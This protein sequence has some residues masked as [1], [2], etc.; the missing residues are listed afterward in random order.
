[1]GVSFVPHVQNQAKPSTP[2]IDVNGLLCPDQRCPAQLDGVLLYRDQ[3][4]LTATAARLLG[5]R[6]VHDLQAESLLP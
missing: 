2:L 5:P 6:L 4:H 1:M 3:S